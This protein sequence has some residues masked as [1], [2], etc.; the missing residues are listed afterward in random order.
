MLYIL[1]N[2]VSFYSSFL[3][4]ISAIREKKQDSIKMH[5]LW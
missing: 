4:L 3:L 2:Y 1:A 5:A